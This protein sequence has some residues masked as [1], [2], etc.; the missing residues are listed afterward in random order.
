MQTY[1]QKTAFLKKKVENIYFISIWSTQHTIKNKIKA[2]LKNRI[3]LKSFKTELFKIKIRKPLNKKC[4]KTNK[5]TKKKMVEKP[6]CR[7]KTQTHSNGQLQNIST[8]AVIIH[9]HSVFWRYNRTEP[10][11]LLDLH[12]CVIRTSYSNND[13]SF[14]LQKIQFE[15]LVE[16]LVKGDLWCFI[17]CF[18][19]FSVLYRF[20][21]T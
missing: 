21:C 18:L 6:E 2:S 20:T 9:L 17:S 12:V 13:I 11:L 5:Q 1:K 4:K 3:N 14:L 10:R 15:D 16:T 8:L 7:N 19:S